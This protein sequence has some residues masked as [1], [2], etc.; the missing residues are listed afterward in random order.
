[1]NAESDELRLSAWFRAWDRPLLRFLSRRGA[2]NEEAEDFMQ[3]AY[4]RLLRMDD[5]DLVRNPQAYLFKIAGNLLSEWR[6]RAA[7]A[8]PHG[9][10]PLEVL[11]A[12]ENPLSD[13]EKMEEQRLIHDALEGLPSVTRKVLLLQAHEDMSYDQIA[14]HLGLTRRMVKRHMLN[15]YSALRSRL[16]D[17]RLTLP[18]AEDR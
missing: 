10:A 6:M 1:M 15:G 7:Q 8:R 18:A 4:L 12:E 11:A 16:G 3:E 13:L 14:R 2:T 5:R 9:P 17:L